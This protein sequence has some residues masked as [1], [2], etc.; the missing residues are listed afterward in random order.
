M[1]IVNH[2]LFW[3]TDGPLIPFLLSPNR[4]SNGIKDVAIV[5]A[6]LVIHYTASTNANGSVNWFLDPKS[7]VSAHL[8]IARDGG[9]TQCVPF[10]QRAW[11]AGESTWAGR[12]DCNSFTIGI[13]LANAGRLETKDGHWQSAYGERIP[14]EQVAPSGEH[15]WQTYTPAQIDAAVAVGRLLVAEYK[16]KGVVGHEDI[17]PGR[18]ID[19]GPLFPMADYRARVITSLMAS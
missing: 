5:P 13:E 17:S 1:K 14:T 3:G 19:P 18:K 6:Y 7:Q 15:A 12:K 2:R 10:N 11:H 4:G 8:V 16:L 9:I